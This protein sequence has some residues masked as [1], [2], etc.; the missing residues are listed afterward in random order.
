MWQP[1]Q[2]TKFADLRL[3][4][5]LDLLSR[6]PGEFEP[7]TIIDL[8]CGPGNITE[9]LAKRYW[10]ASLTGLDSSAEMLANARTNYPQISFVNAD[11]SNIAG[12]Y[13]LIFSNAALHWIKDHAQLIPHLMSCLNPRGILAVQI[14]ANF[15]APSHTLLRQVIQTKPEWMQKLTDSILFHKF[16]QPE[17][18][19][20]L[21]SQYQH[22]VDL[23]TTTYY[24]ILKG[25]NAIVEWVK[26]SIVSNLRAELAPS[27][28]DEIMIIYQELVNKAY[29]KNVDGTTLFPF[30]RL[31]FI[32]QKQ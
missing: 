1:E 12:K 27:E 26:G 21:F 4:P 3:Q 13:D 31:F 24:Q 20:T 19:Y 28:V 30:T 6:I 9:L 11:I 7:E 2:Y 8:G 17:D 29:P 18:Y 5:A 22:K 32:T 25:D 10:D 15:S 23:W 16:W 14:P